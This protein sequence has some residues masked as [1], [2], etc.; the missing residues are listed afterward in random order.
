MALFS[1]FNA[2]LAWVV[3][4]TFPQGVLYPQSYG[5]YK[6]NFLPHLGPYRHLRRNCLRCITSLWGRGH[7]WDYPYMHIPTYTHTYIYIYIHIHTYTHIY[8]HIYTHVYTHTY[9]CI[10]IHIHVC[11]CMC[12]HLDRSRVW[13]LCVR[14][15]YR[16]LRTGTPDS[17]H[18]GHSPLWGLGLS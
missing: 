12:R 4:L 8:I 9:I 5:G 6:I 13:S 2:R 1:F 7:Y 18:P 17:V 15:S 14:Q 16:S 10:Y 3:F 11:I